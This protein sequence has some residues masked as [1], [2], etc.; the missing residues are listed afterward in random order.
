[1]AEPRAPLDLDALEACADSLPDDWW[2]EDGAVRSQRRRCRA[3]RARL[4]AVGGFTV[5]PHR[6]RAGPARARPRGARLPGGD[7]VAPHAPLRWCRTRGGR[8]CAR[9]PHRSRRAPVAY[10][11]PRAASRNARNSA[12]TASRRALTR[13]AS[14]LASAASARAA[15][16]AS[17]AERRAAAMVGAR[18]AT[19][20]ASPSS[21]RAAIC[22]HAST[23][24][25]P[26]RRGFAAS[27]TAEVGSGPGSVAL[28]HTPQR[29]PGAG[30]GASQGPPR[31]RAPP[32]VGGVTVPLRGRGERS[33]PSPEPRMPDMSRACPCIASRTP[34]AAPARRRRP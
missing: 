18:A 14:A 10:S 2:A 15:T 5:S 34:S 17:Q 32:Q 28:P 26:A 11:L 7:D 30:A 22:L 8:P 23:S 9:R 24:A 21:P 1:M 13:A 3:G 31:T 33:G 6:R 19:R 4:R 16:T 29:C 12:E 27:M 25:P 20:H